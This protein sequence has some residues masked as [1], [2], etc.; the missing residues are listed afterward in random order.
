MN[1][2]TNLVANEETTVSSREKTNNVGAV[3]RFRAKT[4]LH[5]EQA[6]WMSSDVFRSEAYRGSATRA[7]INSSEALAALK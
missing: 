3:G 1:L 2:V 7:L 5:S 4:G 6:A